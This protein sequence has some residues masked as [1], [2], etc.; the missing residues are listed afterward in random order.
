MCYLQKTEYKNVIF[1]LSVPGKYEVK[2]GHPAAGDT[3]DK[4]NEILAHLNKTMPCLFPSDDKFQYSITN[5]FD[6]PIYPE[7]NP[8]KRSTPTKTQVLTQTNIDRFLLDIEGY[9]NVILCGNDAQHLERY[10]TD[11]VCIKTCHLGNVGLRNTFMNNHSD[12]KGITSGAERDRMRVKLCADTIS[13]Q[14]MV[15]SKLKKS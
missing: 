5:S 2:A 14:L 10:I 12:L 11:A 8:S 1:V 6:K 4:L 3:G 15:R 13:S 7:N 9:E